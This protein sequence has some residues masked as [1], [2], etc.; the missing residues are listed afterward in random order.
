MPAEWVSLIFGAAVAGVALVALMIVP[1]RAERAILLLV[2]GGLVASFAGLVSLVVRT[3]RVDVAILAALL[4]AGVFAAAY[5][6]ASMIVPIVLKIPAAASIQTASESPAG[7]AVVVS[8][9]TEPAEYDPAVVA[10]TIEHLDRSGVPLPGATGRPIIF[11]GEKARY[12]AVGGES[13]SEWSLRSIT[14]MVR[15]RLD[16]AQFG[17]VVMSGGDTPPRLDAVVAQLGSSGYRRIVVAQLSVADSVRTDRARRAVDDVRPE[18][19]GV[20]VRY[21]PPLWASATIVSMLVDRISAA[22]GST[23]LA[24]CGVALVGHGQPP[25]WQRDQPSANE[26][27]TFFHQRVKRGLL[28]LGLAEQNVRLAWLD[29]QEPDATEVLRHLAAFD[30]DKIIVVPASMP[31][32][33]TSTLVDIGQA[34]HLARLPDETELVRLPAWGDHRAVADALAANIIE[35]AADSKGAGD[36]S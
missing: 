18:A 9:P 16:D 13:P 28:E 36:K 10:S 22:V 4:A 33:G 15:N 35:T 30:C 26:H 17:E 8:S 29:W 27:E 2:L 14:G 12:R 6:V 31:L 34:V 24:R 5:S 3:V 19:N 1:P 20:D 7:A 23:P 11:A 25:E 32:D 21:T